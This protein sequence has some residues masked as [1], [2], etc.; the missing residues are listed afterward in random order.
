VSQWNASCSKD[1]LNSQAAVSYE[2]GISKLVSR[3]DKCLNVQGDCVEKKVKVCDKT[4]I[5]CFFPI[6]SKYLCMAERS[7]LSERPSYFC[8]VD[9]TFLYTVN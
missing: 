6:I 2:E 1:W 8:T 4:C 9:Y 3:Y 7:L 5:F